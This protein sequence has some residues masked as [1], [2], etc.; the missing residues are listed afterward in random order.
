MIYVFNKIKLIFFK[1]FNFIIGVAV[2]IYFYKIFK[3]DLE[4]NPEHNGA[5]DIFGYF[6][7]YSTE[8]ID[9]CQEWSDK[10]FIVKYIFSLLFWGTIYKLIY[11]LIN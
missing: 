10:L 7:Q 5:F 8:M 9:Y 4:S 2:T 6:K 11:L 1:P 3:K